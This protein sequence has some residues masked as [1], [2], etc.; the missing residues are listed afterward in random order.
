MPCFST[1]L[2]QWSPALGF[3]RPVPVSAGQWP[4]PGWRG[5]LPRV[6]V[7]GAGEAEHFCCGGGISV[8]VAKHLTYLC[9][10]LPCVKQGNDIL[11]ALHCC[12]EAS[13]MFV[14]HF[15]DG[16][17]CRGRCQISG[18]HPPSLVPGSLLHF[19]GGRKSHALP[20]PFSCSC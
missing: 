19:R 3:P 8:P 2:P 7:S 6:G 12:W 14:N 11:F 9:L 15:K 20:V 10:H 18:L 17:D 1:S 5:R 13:L 16:S 4:C